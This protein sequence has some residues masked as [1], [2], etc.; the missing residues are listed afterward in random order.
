[1]ESFDG[2]TTYIPGGSGKLL[3]LSYLFQNNIELAG[4]FA[5]VK[6]VQAIETL[7]QGGNEI[8]LGLTKYFSG[9][10]VKAQLNGMYLNDHVLFSE[11]LDRL[12]ATFQVEVGL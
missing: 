9:H 2:E 10:R 7:T 12:G 3:Q 11:R 1:V 8:T 4:R 5:Q 6:P